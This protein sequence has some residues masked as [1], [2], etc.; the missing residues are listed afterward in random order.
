MSFQFPKI[1]PNN[2]KMGNPKYPIWVSK[3]E[4]EYSS[5]PRNNDNIFLITQFFIHSNKDRADEIRFCLKQNINGGFFSKIYLVNEQKYTQDELGLT[6]EEFNKVY[7]IVTGVRMDFADAIKQ[8]KAYSMDGY[9]VIANSDI[10]FDKTIFNLRKGTLKDEPGV[11][12][13]LRFEYD[14]TKR[15][16]GYCKL[17]GPRPDSQDVWILHSNWVPHKK[18]RNKHFKITLG[19]PGCD[20]TIAWVFHEQGYRVFNEPYRIKTYHYHSTQIRNYSKKDVTSP[21]FLFIEPVV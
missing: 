12:C 15:K 18:I 1:I 17:F 6:K 20:N 13:L 10:F 8:V 14:N 11:Q 19:M 5:K 9:I 3:R 21:P 2:L 4:D 16:L 7:Q